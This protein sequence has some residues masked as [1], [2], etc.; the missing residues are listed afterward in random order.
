M[1]LNRDDRIILKDL[2]FYGYHGVMPEEGKIGARFV[3]DLE[4]GLDTRRAAQTDEVEDTISYALIFECVQ[5]AFTDSRYKLLEALA[6][7]ICDRLFA[8][9]DRIDW[10]RVRVCKPEAP[11]PT[12]QGE[13]AVE[14][15]R[16]RPQ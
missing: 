12:V 15:V 14:I 1:N 10:V 3:V 13:F 2:A 8:A 6:Q 11:I 5:A 16:E 4:C 7:N 9:Q